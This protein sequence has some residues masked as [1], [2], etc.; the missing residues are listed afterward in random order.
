MDG[1]GKARWAY[2]SASAA[3][4]PSRDKNYHCRRSFSER[5]WEFHRRAVDIL[6]FRRR[7]IVADFYFGHFSCL[8]ISKWDF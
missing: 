7:K 6:Q 2:V 8:S 1:A 3:D 4:R 5:R